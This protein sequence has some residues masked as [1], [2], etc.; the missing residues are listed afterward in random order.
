MDTTNE[1]DVRSQSI[2]N[3]DKSDIITILVATDIHLGFEEKDPIRGQDSINTFE[4]ILNIA[5]VNE[6]DF[7]LLGGDLFHYARP[8]PYSIYKCTELLRRYCFGDKPVEIEFL[9]DPSENFK[10]CY[11]PVVNYEDPNLNVSI[12]VFSIHGNHDDPTGQKQ[13]SAMDLLSSSGLVNYFG[14]WN[15]LDKVEVEPILLQKGETKLTLLGLSHIKDERLGRLFLDKKVKFMAPP[16]NDQDWFNLL[17][18]HQNR[19]TRGVKNFIPDDSLPDFLDLVIWGHEHDCRIEPESKA[20]GVQISQPG[21]SVATSLALGE[22]ITKKV[23]ILKIHKKLSKMI[24]VELKTVRPFIF[25]ELVLK[26]LNQLIDECDGSLTP[27]EITEDIVTKK[28]DEMIEQA[29]TLGRTPDVSEK[30]LIRL[31]VKVRDEKQVFNTIRF[32]QS[33]VGKVAN[34]EDMV[35][36][37]V[38]R[39]P[40]RG[41]KKGDG[42]S[43]SDTPIVAE[44]VE[45]I[46]L[47]HFSEN[48]LLKVFPV[49][50]L[51]ESVKKHIDANDS[52]AFSLTVEHLIKE[53]LDHLA[54]SM[55]E[56]EDIESVVNKFRI[57][58]EQASLS[59][60]HRLLND[61]NRQKKRIPSNEDKKPMRQGSDENDDVMVIDDDD[62]DDNVDIGIQGGSGLWANSPKRPSRGPGSRGGRGSRRPRAARGRAK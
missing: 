18:W 54:E 30:P 6:V 25:Q 5:V 61:P 56:I 36:C 17:V 34:P 35:K 16:G 33:Y 48:D 1:E 59:S 19:A 40:I 42:I 29:K 37:N 23:G 49:G 60:V 39:Q 55:P 50:P 38:I 43:L 47:E 46:V 3:I 12:P 58:R 7:I 11:N 22:A 26:E 44:R 32:G 4:E 27:I 51:V 57:S 10:S 21:S 45:D 31:N 15:S 52:E 8:S 2:D 53:T 9:S 20:N 14:R 62:A 24:P 28:V 13:I 41:D